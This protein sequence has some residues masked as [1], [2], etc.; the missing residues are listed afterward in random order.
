MPSP[1]LRP[2]VLAHVGPPEA[3]RN[4]MVDLEIAARRLYAVGAENFLLQRDGCLPVPMTVGVPVDNAAYF[5]RVGRCDFAR[6]EHIIGSDHF[7]R[8]SRLRWA[9]SSEDLHPVLIA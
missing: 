9:A 1:F 2:K 8:S 3:Q 7:F 6:R 5:L 4:A